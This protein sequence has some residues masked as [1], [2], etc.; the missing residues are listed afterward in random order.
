MKLKAGFG[1]LEKDMNEKIENERSALL[2]T[3]QNLIRDAELK[4]TNVKFH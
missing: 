3:S 4:A 2:L 1:T